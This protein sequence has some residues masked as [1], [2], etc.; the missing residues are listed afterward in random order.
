MKS[1]RARHPLIQHGGVIFLGQ[2]LL[3]L[4]VPLVDR[5]D[6]HPPVEMFAGTIAVSAVTVLLLGRKQ[7][8][9]GL[10]VISGL[11]VIGLLLFGETIEIRLPATILI[12]VAYI[13]ASWLSVRHAF[14]A[15]VK[16]SQRI[17]CGAAAFVMLGFMFSVLHAFLGLASPDTYVL[18]TAIAG[19]RQPHWIDF[20]WLSFSTLTT[21]GYGDLAPVGR[22]ANALCTLEALCGI[23]FPAT[24]IARIASLP[25]TPSV[26]APP[27]SSPP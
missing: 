17:L 12:M 25:A 7:F 11:A 19:A 3:V 21:A 10:A 2:I 4:L 8:A 18:T 13:W 22:W 24:L 20:V 14:S 1:F 27:S 23:L 6:V 16:A 5:G 26:T 15:D 9:I